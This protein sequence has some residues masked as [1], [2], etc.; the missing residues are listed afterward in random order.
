LVQP[1]L[2]GVGTDLQTSPT[3]VTFID[4]QK[5]LQDISFRPAGTS[6]ASIPPLS[7]KTIYIACYGNSTI[8]YY[9]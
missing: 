6:V 7:G 3:A 4:G 8:S 2:T 9:V 5:K 1:I